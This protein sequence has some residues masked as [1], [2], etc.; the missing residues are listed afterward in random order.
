MQKILTETWA[1]NEKKGNVTDKNAVWRI[2]L[3]EMDRMGFAKKAK[4]IA[5]LVCNEPDQS[6][7]I[8][9]THT[10]HHRRWWKDNCGKMT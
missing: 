2:V 9:Y 4:E 6:E 8:W 3:M 7:E 5:D 1:M 10:P